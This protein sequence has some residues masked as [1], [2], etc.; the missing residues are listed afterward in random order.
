M[1][2]K[3]LAMGELT[4]PAWQRAF[5]DT[6]RHVFVPDHDLADAYSP[7]APVT[8]WRTADELGNKRP[9]SSASAPGAVA[10]MLERLNVQDH[11]RI[12]EIGTGTG[13]NAALL[14]HRLGAANVYSDEIDPALVN[15]AR[16]ALTSLG[17]HPTLV[18][19]NGYTGLADGAPYDRI[20]ATCAI[21]H[22]PPE[23][24][25]QLAIGGRIIAPI[26]GNS[27]KPLIILDKTAPDEV[28][29]H[30]D[31][32]DVGFMPLRH[33]L[34]SPLG[35][36]ETASSTAFGMAPLWHH[37]NRSPSPSRS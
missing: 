17:Y 9:T 10:V 1:T 28:T 22:I 6:P 32:Y 2:E 13:Y 21:T 11:Q 18:A 27:T 23:W 14:C 20:L 16:H 33:D 19:T 25:R 3:L 37:H 12:L 7:T 8:Q 36:G 29:G 15:Q 30:F 34:H 35:P 5:T 4:D 24:I 26:A 31:N